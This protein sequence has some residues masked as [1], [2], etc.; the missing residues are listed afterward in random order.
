[1]SEKPYLC[2]VMMPI[3][4]GKDR[5]YWKDILD[6]IIRPSV[7]TSRF[8]IKV[9]RVDELPGSGNWLKKIVENTHEADIVVADL[10]T[11][12]PNVMWELGM[13]HACA[14]H[15]TVILTQSHGDVPSDLRSYN[16]F[17]Y[18]ED[19]SDLDDVKELVGGCLDE[20]LG[21]GGKVDSP[22]FDFVGETGVARREIGISFIVDDVHVYAETVEVMPPGKPDVDSI[23][24]DAPAVP[25]KLPIHSGYVSGEAE[26]YNRAVDEFAGR[27]EKVKRQRREY[28]AAASRAVK[29]LPV[30]Q[31]DGGTAIEDVQVTMNFEGQCR[32]LSEMPSLPDYPKLPPRPKRR[33]PAGEALGRALGIPDLTGM[34][35]YNPLRTWDQPVSLGM[36]QPEIPGPYGG[37]WIEG[38]E[39]WCHTD[40]IRQQSHEDRWDPFYLVLGRAFTEGTVEVVVRCDGVRGAPLRLFKLVLVGSKSKSGDVGSEERGEDS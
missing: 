36:F 12:N 33:D 32:L 13:R 18:E 15:G 27:L 3:K 39:A 22:F 37:C 31:N 30:I 35:P 7:E 1:M 20:I 8:D 34:L 14:P 17:T 11:T 40:K 28:A 29:L 6:R 21:G 38:N 9:V 10:T 24:A 19:G 4:S 2:F 16:V 23:I 26:E 25:S 5:V